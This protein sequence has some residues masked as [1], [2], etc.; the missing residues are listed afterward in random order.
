[1]AFLQNGVWVPDQPINIQ[2]PTVG[3][4]PMMAI[5]GAAPQV[6]QQQT[7]MQ[8]MPQAQM[9]MPTPGISMMPM[10]LGAV[11]QNQPPA[12]AIQFS[13]PQQAQNAYGNL[14]ASNIPTAPPPQVSQNQ[15]SPNQFGGGG[16]MQPRSVMQS[17]NNANPQSV[18]N[19]LQALQQSQSTSQNNNWQNPQGTQ[20]QG[21]QAGFQ[22]FN[23]PNPPPYQ[24]TNW[25][26]YQQSNPFANMQIQAPRS[27]SNNQYNNLQVPFK[28]NTTNNLQAPQL[29]ENVHQGNPYGQPA[30]KQGNPYP[31]N[32]NQGKSQG[33]SPY[34]NMIAASDRQVKQEIQPGASELQ[35]FL[36]SL[37][38]YSYEYKDPKYGEGRRISPMAQE[39]ERTPLGKAAISTNQEG[40]KTVDYGKL[41]GTMLASLA[42]LNNKYNKL[43]AQ[44]KQ[45]IKEGLKK[46]GKLHGDSE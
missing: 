27:N 6:A 40:Y 42:L 3:V 32:T 34:S 2:A 23:Q 41:G 36:N 24:P 13:A 19:F 29:S 8:S 14:S 31:E 20:G 16:N 21:P 17:V 7:R 38:V 18:Q 1:M 33:I 4:S 30:P 37:G 5:E 44:L 26:S 15:F 28:S 39:I 35:D 11:P 43:E 12:N 46:K 9:Q 45:S 25:Q 22:G 10:N